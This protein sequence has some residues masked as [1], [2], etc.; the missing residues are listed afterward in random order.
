MEAIIMERKTGQLS[1]LDSLTADIGGRRT[2]EF[3]QKCNKLI[4]WQLLA[5]PLKGMYRNNTDKGGASLGLVEMAKRSGNQLLFSFTDIDVKASFFYFN[6]EIVTDTTKNNSKLRPQDKKYLEKI[7]D[8]HKHLNKEDVLLSFKGDFSQDNVIYLL[9]MLRS[10]MPESTTSIKINNILIELLQNIEKHADNINE[11]TDWKPGIFLINRK[12]NN[13]YLTAGNYLSNSKRKELEGKLE[14]INSLDKK[15]LTKL[16][17]E[18]I[19]NTKEISSIKTGL[20]IIDIKRKSLNEIKYS[21][22]KINE[23]YSFFIIQIEIKN[24]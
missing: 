12:N 3:F 8:F 7:I 15:E 19:L 17:K 11:V 20:G 6:T 5:Q 10:Q 16:Y 18:S 1:F 22:K 2:A 24:K 21:F 13:Y 4:P 14:H 9:E 23:N